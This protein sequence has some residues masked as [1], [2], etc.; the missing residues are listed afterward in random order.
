LFLTARRSGDIQAR[1]HCGKRHVGQRFARGRSKQVE[2]AMPCE[3]EP[4]PYA[5]LLQHLR[6]LG[7]PLRFIRDDKTPRA[8]VVLEGI[9]RRA[10]VTPLDGKIRIE[11]SIQ[12]VEISSNA[13][14]PPH[15]AARVLH[16]FCVEQ[17]DCA[18]LKARHPGLPVSERALAHALTYRGQLS[19]SCCTGFTYALNVPFV[20][21]VI[22]DP[23]APFAEA[24]RVPPDSGPAIHGWW[25]VE[26]E[27]VESVMP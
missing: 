23:D 26:A 24:F 8:D 4:D 18:E 22:D 12:G 6:L 19:F 2:A 9:P 27:R 3:T 25:D 11:M 17:V 15:R 1:Q 13:W 16:D 7:S 14:L 10:N 21:P 5:R 20:H